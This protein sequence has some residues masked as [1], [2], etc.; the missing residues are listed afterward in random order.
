MTRSPVCQ[1]VK[2]LLL[3]RKL[4]STFAEKFCKLQCCVHKQGASLYE[5]DVIRDF[6]SNDIR[7]EL[8]VIAV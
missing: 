7:T 6:R 4:F 3:G 5:A 2:K 8:L 1:I